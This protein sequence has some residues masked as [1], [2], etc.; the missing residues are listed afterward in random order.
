MSCLHGIAHADPERW[1]CGS[2]NPFVWQRVLP[3]TPLESW[4]HPV[5]ND[6]LELGGRPKPNVEAFSY[7]RM[8]ANHRLA[9]YWVDVA[10]GAAVATY[11]PVE[12]EIR[13]LSA[14]LLQIPQVA[15]PEVGDPGHEEHVVD[16]VNCGVNQGHRDGPHL[17]HVHVA[18][19]QARSP[20]RNSTPG[21]E[22]A[23]QNDCQR[24]P[25]S[26]PDDE[27]CRILMGFQKGG[28]F[29]NAPQAAQVSGIPTDEHRL[30]ALH[31]GTHIDHT[32]HLELGIILCDADL[33][34]EDLPR[35][36]PQHQA[37]AR[38]DQASQESPLNR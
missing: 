2:Q 25:A 33:V 5:A 26:R 36:A 23:E 20:L 3:K 4:R 32:L 27:L 13:E 30:R 14:S 17:L 7:G 22:C 9:R 6:L 28:H 10:N 35:G 24:A 34:K 15:A 29:Q 31:G 12:A 16:R 11:V 21:P 19:D 1:D 18:Q 8:V 38:S 37:K